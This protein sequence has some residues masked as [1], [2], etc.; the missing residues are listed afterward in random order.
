MLQ[1]KTRC[2]ASWNKMDQ[3]AD[4]NRFCHDCKKVVHDLT[5]L[6]KAEG[7]KLYNESGGSLCGRMVNPAFQAMPRVAQQASG[8][9][10]RLN[11]SQ[12]RVA[13]SAAAFVLLSQT[14]LLSQSAPSFS[15]PSSKEPL[16]KHET[17]AVK[18]VIIVMGDVMVNETADPLIK[19]KEKERKHQN[20]NEIDELS[21]DLTWTKSDSSKPIMRY[22]K[23]PSEFLQ[24]V[25]RWCVSR[26]LPAGPVNPIPS[27]E[28]NFNRIPKAIPLNEYE[29]RPV[30]LVQQTPEKK[31]PLPSPYFLAASAVP[32]LRRR[33][34]L[35]KASQ[36][37]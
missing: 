36:N 1:I 13:A 2:T 22:R 4:G 5:S 6:S 17:Q 35:R 26:P 23:M 9:R 24:T 25:S 14:P 16:P 37:A 3:L 20:A 11:L 7:L 19:M 21:D 34:R 30:G 27:E 28:N 8:Y 18:E 31:R 33:Y 10:L 29:A 15:R 12:M 32:V